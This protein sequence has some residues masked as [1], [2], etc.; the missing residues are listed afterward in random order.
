MPTLVCWHWTLKL[1]ARF[2]S[3][4][5]EVAR[6]AADKAAALLWATEPFIQSSNYCYYRALTA[7]ALHRTDDPQ[8]HAEGLDALHRHLGQ[9]REWANACPDTFIDKYTLVSAEIARLEGRELDAQRLYEDA[10]RSAREHGFV[11]NEAIGNEV[12]A[13]FY[14]TRGL[15]TIAHAYLRHARHCY[16]RWGAAGKVR[17]LERDHPHLRDD[18]A[19]PRLT[20]T[21]GAPIDQIDVATVVKASQAVLGEI[22]LD[23]LIKTLMTMALEHAGAE[24]GVLMLLRR[25]QLLI[26]AEAATGPGSVDVVLRQAAPEP[27]ELPASL[28]HTVIRTRK[29]VILDDAR[30]S[31]Q[32]TDDEYVVRRRPR[33]VLCLPLVKQAEL[34]GLIYLENNL[35]PGTF[36]P[37]RI[38][39]LELLASQAAI[40]LENARLYAKLMAENR[41]RTKVEAS[42]AEGQRMSLT[43]SWRWNVT[44]GAVQWSAEHFRIFGMDPAVHTPSYATYISRVHPDDLFLVQQDLARAA[45]EAHAFRH[46]YR[47]VMPDGVIK[48]VQSMGRPDVDQNDELEFVG[49]IMDITERRHAEEALRRSQM[50]LARV[51]RL[52]T[53]GELAGSIIHEINQP[54]GAVIG[55]AEVCLRWLDRDPPDIAEARDSITRLARDG[56]RAADVIKG[57]RALAR[58]SGLELTNVDINSAIREVLVLLRG[59]MERGAVVLRVDLFH[60][61]RPVNGD[62]VQLQQVLLNLI[63]NGIE[64]MSAVSDRPRVLRIS[65]ELTEAGEALVAVE[66]SGIGLSATTADRIFEPLFTT[67][68]NGMGMGLSVCRSIVEAHHGRL[69]ALPNSPY[70]TIFRFTVPC[71]RPNDESGARLDSGAGVATPHG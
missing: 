3:G 13:R 33:S 2:I 24:R 31:N 52:S 65:S 61:A 40:S 9:L 53:M 45:R 22:V 70:G 36:T 56:R 41:E 54:L 50:E 28:L 25:N 44:T 29:G 35:A 16:A 64:A 12:A 66:D 4:D 6:S 32:F 71:A 63:R 47:L 17:Q 38:A 5:F 58:K 55:N 62:R 1:Q 69:A 14:A 23:R 26:E 10:I 57:L 21:I 15:E 7:A 43:G 20:T 67:K 59:E 18:L 39:V 42:L 8:G 34:T 30:Q 11:H 51:S 27:A 49:T 68:L 46:E 19:S 37:R 60:F 48:H